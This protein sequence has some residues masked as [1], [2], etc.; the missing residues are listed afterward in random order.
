LS[1]FESRKL[2]PGGLVISAGSP[3][4]GV[5]EHE[6]DK[7]A[8]ESQLRENLDAALDLIWQ[9]LVEDPRGGVDGLMHR[10]S[11]LQLNETFTAVFR[12]TTTTGSVSLIG[13]GPST[14][15]L[16]LVLDQDWAEVRSYWR[17]V[18]FRVDYLWKGYTWLSE[19]TYAQLVLAPGVHLISSAYQ[20]EPR[21]WEERRLSAMADETFRCKAGE[22]VGYRLRR[23][24]DKFR[25]EHH[26][27]LERVDE[28]DLASAVSGKAP[29]LLPDYVI[30]VDRPSR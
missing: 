4:Y 18:P 21:L 30:A 24:D 15:A 8:L 25:A 3:A 22:T 27:K 12:D 16:V 6:H 5:I 14:C 19:A 23:E 9:D 7:P 26:L 17:G 11:V 10:M 28:V 29:L 20:G 2:R 13:P 1:A